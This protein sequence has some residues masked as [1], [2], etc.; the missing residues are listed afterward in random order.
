MLYLS[1]YAIFEKTPE[2]DLLTIKAVLES[3]IF[4]R[5]IQLKSKD[6]RVGW[7]ACT[8]HIIQEF[9]IPNFSANEKIDLQQMDS[10]ELNDF[11]SYKYMVEKS[12]L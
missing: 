10:Y 2:L 6:Y 9:T 8:K 1:G 11:L 12:L 7:K 3:D 4:N 5:Y